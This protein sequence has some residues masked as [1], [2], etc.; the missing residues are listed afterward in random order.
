[1][2]LVQRAPGA[3]PCRNQ[4][5]SSWSRFTDHSAS[6]SLSTVIFI[7]RIFAALGE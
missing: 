7:A 2:A 3:L 1:M 4:A 5:M 6:R